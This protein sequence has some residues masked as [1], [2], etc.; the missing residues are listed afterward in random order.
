M[1]DVYVIKQNNLVK[2]EDETKYNH[3]NVFVLQVVRW[4]AT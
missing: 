1:I 3:D 2:K 4:Q